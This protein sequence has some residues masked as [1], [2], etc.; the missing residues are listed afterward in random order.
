MAGNMGC[1]ELEYLSGEK[2]KWVQIWQHLSLGRRY[3]SIMSEPDWDPEI[4]TPHPPTPPQISLTA[5]SICL[6]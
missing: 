1:V 5:L 3:T 6:F 4:Y 2:D